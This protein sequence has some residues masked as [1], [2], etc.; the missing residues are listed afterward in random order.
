MGQLQCQVLT[1]WQLHAFASDA[2]SVLFPFVRLVGYTDPPVG[3]Q[4]RE[5][6]EPGFVIVAATS[7]MCCGSNACNAD[8]AIS[9][10]C[11]Q[12]DTYGYLNGHLLRCK[13]HSSRPRP[14]QQ[15]KLLAM[16]TTNMNTRRGTIALANTTVLALAQQV[17][18]GNERTRHE[19]Y[20]SLW[21]LVQSSQKLQLSVY[22]TLVKQQLL[23]RPNPPSS[24][25]L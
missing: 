21:R 5:S 23:Q 18:N 2:G 6:F 24:C 3:I 14:F 13:R 11:S 20:G 16:A 17:L 9:L 15:K 22:E 8:L 19:S 1:A 12:K 4:S 7:G 25:Q 10:Y